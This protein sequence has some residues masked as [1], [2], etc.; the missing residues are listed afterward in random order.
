MTTPGT[1]PWWAFWLELLRPTLWAKSRCEVYEADGWLIF[2]AGDGF[3]SPNWLEVRVALG[4]LDDSDAVQ[5]Q[6]R[7]AVARAGS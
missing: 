1:D 4:D 6:L 3:S 5:A 7:E 2:E